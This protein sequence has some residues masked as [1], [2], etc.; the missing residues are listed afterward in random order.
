MR[1]RGM[2]SARGQGWKRIP[3]ERLTHLCRKAIDRV[4]VIRI[5]YRTRWSWK[6]KQCNGWE[7]KRWRVKEV[8]GENGLGG[9]AVGLNNY[10]EALSLLGLLKFASKYIGV[11]GLDRDL[12]L[13]EMKSEWSRGWKRF[14]EIELNIKKISRSCWVVQ[15]RFWTRWI[16]RFGQRA[17][18]VWD[19]RRAKK[20]FWGRD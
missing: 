11:A 4:E 1:E 20:G 18:N 16:C 2:K 8:G 14:L 3:E 10:T 13:K 5:C 17:V 12:R 6:H 9:G 19:A 15:I 7:W